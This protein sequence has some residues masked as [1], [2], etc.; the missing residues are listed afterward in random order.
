[1]KK[2][3]KVILD[4]DDVLYE[5]NSIAI[6]KLNQ[7]I[8]TKYK[9][10][11]IKEWGLTGTSI[12]ERLKYYGDSTFIRNLPL[13]KGAKEFV[14][15]LSKKAEIFVCTSVQPSCAS[16]RLASI[17]KNFPEIKVSNIMIGGRK[18]MLV[19]DFMLD[20][21]ILNL[22]K[23]QVTYPVLMQRPWN[24]KGNAGML[25]VNGYEQ[26]LQLIDTVISHEGSSTYD[27]CALIG[28]SGSGKTKIAEM[29]CKKNFEIVPTYT[30]A[31]KNGEQ[32]IY[33]PEKEFTSKDEIGFFSETSTYMGEKYG[34]INDDIEYILYRKKIP[35]LILDINGTMAVSRVYS[36]LSCFVEAP[37]SVCV[38]NILNKDLPN[39]VKVERICSLDGELKN[40]ELCDI[41]I[42]GI[43]PNIDTILQ[44]LGR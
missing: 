1:M 12:D 35:L 34:I 22:E 18:D 32:Y 38:E 43:K 31:N 6:K 14:H 41:S 20:D 2:R 23:A 24:Q 29:L 7:E 5:C 3:I 17:I 27:I 28:P 4:C 39:D 9:L 19:A 40:K 21:C 44:Q 42:L 26:F 33:I 13:I 30:T 10:E 8:G 36:T 16:E 37:K 15:R 11:D 25:S